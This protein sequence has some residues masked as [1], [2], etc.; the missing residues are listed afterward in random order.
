MGLLT[1]F[2]GTVFAVLL[3]AYFIQ[4]FH[5]DGFYTAVIVALVLGLLNVTLKPII[6]LLTLPLNLLTLG[7]FSFV[8][9]A[10]LILLISTFVK[11]FTVDGFLPALWAGAL[12]AVVGWILHKLSKK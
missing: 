4:G 5:V 6:T 10:G 8:I 9:N 3:A 1:R 2:L 12:I 7:L 11:G